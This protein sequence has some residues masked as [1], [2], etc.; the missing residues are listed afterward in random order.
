MSRFYLSFSWGGCR[1]ARAA[2]LTAV[3]AEAV[4][5]A[6]A[7]DSALNVLDASYVVIGRVYRQGGSYGYFSVAP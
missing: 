3:R 7:T 6:E 4:Q 5:A 1:L 2:D